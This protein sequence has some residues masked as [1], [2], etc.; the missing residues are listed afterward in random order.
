MIK[1]KKIKIIFFIFFLLFPALSF[2]QPNKLTIIRD[3]EIED[4]LYEISRPIFT[5][6]ELNPDSIK[7]YIIQDK[8]INAFVAGGQNIFVNTGTLTHFDKPDAL[9]GIIAHET[10]HIAGGHLAKISEEVANQQKFVAG[11]MIIGLLSLLAGSPEGMQASLLGGMHIGQQNILSYSR[12]Q[13]RSADQYAVHFLLANNLSPDALLKSMK[14]FKRDELNISDNTEYYTTH[15]L[16]KNR[17][18]FIKANINPKINN[19]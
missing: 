10:G 12:T 2:A 7:F 13:E 15:P 11:S 4:F 19:N 17:I 14:E 5:T 18:Q 1:N 9:L 8:N 3:T 16:S 6:A